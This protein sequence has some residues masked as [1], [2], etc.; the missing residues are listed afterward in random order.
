LKLVPAACDAAHRDPANCCA[1]HGGPRCAHFDATHRPEDLTLMSV[2]DLPKQTPV[3]STEEAVMRDVTRA[4]GGE[5][6][7]NPIWSYIR[8]PVSV[9]NQGGCSMS[10]AEDS[11]TDPSGAVRHYPGLFVFDAAAFP[12]SVGVNPSATILAVAERNVEA[13]I[14]KTLGKADWQPACATVAS[15]WAQKRTAILRPEALRVLSNSPPPK[16]E[17]IGIEFTEEM[18]GFVAAPAADATLPGTL[19]SPGQADR[20]AYEDAENQGRMNDPEVARMA[21]KLRV[22]APDLKAF[23]EDPTHTL[24]IEGTVELHGTY[25]ELDQHPLQGTLQLFSRGPDP[26]LRTMRYELHVG[27][28]SP[29]VERIIGTKLVSNDPGPDVWPDTSRLYVDLLAGAGMRVGL[30]VLHLSLEGFLFQ[31]LPSTRVTGTTDEAQMAWAIASFGSCFFGNIQ[32]AY[33]PEAT[34]IGTLVKEALSLGS[35]HLG[36]SNVPFRGVPY[37]RPH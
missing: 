7:L 17:P 28:G 4:L 13:F 11:V 32:K 1:L 37:R 22:F 34:Q 12:R 25:G 8:R 24:G 30:G 26:H 14:R 2:F 29:L 33:M 23:L 36:R 5:L 10:D 9:H 21:L 27:K 20:P 31:Q 35:P 19:P 18:I 6:R 15:E 3:Y 16:A